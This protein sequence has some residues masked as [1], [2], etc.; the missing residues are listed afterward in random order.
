MSRRAS[1]LALVTAIA[2]TIAACGGDT[3]T[4]TTAGDEGTTTAAPGTTASPDTTAAPRR[5]RLSSVEVPPLATE[6]R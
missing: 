3:G 5:V 4:T 1:I 6:M 2:L